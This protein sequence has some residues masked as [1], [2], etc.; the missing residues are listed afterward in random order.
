MKI[1]RKIK[2]LMNM[3]FINISWHQNVHMKKLQTSFF[4]MRIGH[5]I[6]HQLEIRDDCLLEL[7]TAEAS[8]LNSF[9]QFNVECVKEIPTVTSI[10]YKAITE[11]V[12]DL[13]P[14]NLKI[15][16]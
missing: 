15:L 12:A 5:A 2:K 1:R 6:H 11:G 9:V 10:A 4:C 7:T 8:F 3:K 14:I 16:V 13:Y